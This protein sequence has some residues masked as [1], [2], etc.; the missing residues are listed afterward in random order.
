MISEHPIREQRY[1]K[2]LKGQEVTFPCFYGS[3]FLYIY[4]VP[5]TPDIIKGGLILDSSVK[6]YLGKKPW[7]IVPQISLVISSQLWI[8]PSVGNGL[9]INTKWSLKIQVLIGGVTF[10]KEWKSRMNSFKNQTIAV[11]WQIIESLYSVTIV[12]L[13][14]DTWTRTSKAFTP[15]LQMRPASLP[16]HVPIPGLVISAFFIRDFSGAKLRAYR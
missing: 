4:Y 8:R 1:L 15:T 9:Q 5:T 3:T 12:C 7:C 16:Y 6:K 10:F 2:Y 13:I 14:R 11:Q